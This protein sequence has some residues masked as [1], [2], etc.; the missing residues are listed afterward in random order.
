MEQKYLENYI[1]IEDSG[2]FVERLHGFPGVY[3][4]YVYKTIKGYEA[5]LNLMEGEWDRRAKFETC[6]GL[7]GAKTEP[8]LFTGRCLGTLASKARGTKG[9]G[10]DPIFIPHGEQS[11]F[12]EMDMTEKNIYSHRAL[13]VEKLKNYLDGLI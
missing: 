13:A 2:L 1:M 4:A 8:R 5:I 11:T 9:F 12:A 3:S 10:Y 6:I 7:A